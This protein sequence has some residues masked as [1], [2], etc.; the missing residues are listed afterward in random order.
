LDGIEKELPLDIVISGF[1]IHHQ[2]DE[3]KK[4]IYKDIFD[5]SLKPGGLF[6]NLD[7]VRSAT[8]HSGA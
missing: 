7:Q 2:T 3:N 5:K 6:L 4:R 1:A 8:P